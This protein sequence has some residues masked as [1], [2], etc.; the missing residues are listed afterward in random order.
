MELRSSR[1]AMEQGAAPDNVKRGPGGM[2]DVEFIAQYF[3][4][5]SANCEMPLATGTQA[6]LAA[7]ARE[8]ILPASMAESLTDTYRFLLR[9]ESGL[10]LLNTS[11]RHDLPTA[12]GQL[13]QL[14][15]LLGHGNPERMRSQ[16][17]AA[18][19][20]NRAT[21]NELFPLTP[22]S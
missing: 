4:L 7:L 1:L 13:E 8:K 17:L 9:I 2:L 3:Q 14:A 18:M 11:A 15:Y 16:C 19:A 21:F 22:D 20:Q 12:P 10:R 6:A 5:Q